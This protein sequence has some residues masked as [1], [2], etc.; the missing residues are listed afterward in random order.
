M[1]L[2]HQSA[3][4]FMGHPEHQGANCG[5]PSGEWIC[6]YG[7]YTQV[8]VSK[9]SALGFSIQAIKPRKRPL[10]CFLLVWFGFFFSVDK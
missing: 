7:G 8:E 5:V 10:V 9:N 2:L 1:I 3:S 6:E 4:A